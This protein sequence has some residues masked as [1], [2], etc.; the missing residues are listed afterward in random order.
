MLSIVCV[1]VCVCVCMC[2]HSTTPNEG[3]L[4][5][6]NGT[7]ALRDA[8]AS[9]CVCVCVFYVYCVRGEVG[10]E[11]GKNASGQVSNIYAYTHTHT[12][13]HTHIHLPFLGHVT[14]VS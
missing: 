7:E 12:H 8:V 9:V 3:I 13:T 1:C 11:K 2:L 6:I 5:R 14:Y 10:H 4:E